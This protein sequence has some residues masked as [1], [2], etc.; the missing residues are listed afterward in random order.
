MFDA[1]EEEETKLSGAMRKPEEPTDTGREMR[2][3]KRPR[4]EKMDLNVS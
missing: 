1:G 2:I 3:S 4:K